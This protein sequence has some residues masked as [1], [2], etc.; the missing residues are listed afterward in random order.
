MLPAGLLP[1]PEFI[2]PSTTRCGVAH[3]ELVTPAAVRKMHHWL[4]CRLSRREVPFYQMT[5]VC[6]ELM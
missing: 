4:A 1:Q 5:L 2:A 3:S 6:V